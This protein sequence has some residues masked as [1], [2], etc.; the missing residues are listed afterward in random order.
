MRGVQ[1][2][3]TLWLINS[4]RSNNSRRHKLTSSKAYQLTSSPTQKLI[5]PQTH[6]LKNSSTHKLINSKAHQLKCPSIQKLINSST[7]QLTNSKAHQLTNSPTQKLINSLT[8]KLKT[9]NHRLFILQNRSNFRSV[10]AKTLAKKLVKCHYFYPFAPWHLSVFKPRTCILHHF[11]F[12]FCLPA[13]YLL[14]P[15]Y[16]LLAPKTP[17]FTHILPL[18]S[19]CF[20]ARRGFVYTIAVDVYA[21]TS[22]V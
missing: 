22:C 12:L 9:L 20:M 8:H 19:M 13:H 7:H 10:L 21:K 16:A 6:Q 5:N 15:N 18:Q 17:L 14:P 11:A 1:H 4:L 2:K 3:S